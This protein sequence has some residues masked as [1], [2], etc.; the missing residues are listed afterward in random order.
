MKRTAWLVNV[1]RGRL[2]VERALLRALH[3]GAIAGAV[4]DAF[5]DEPL[6]PDSPFYGLPN[7]IVT[8]QTSW[9]SG[10]VLRATMELFAENL[11]RYRAGEPLLNMVDPGAGY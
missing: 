11:R 6:L 2:I 10:R 3:E 8:P 1:A 5:R 4:L 9:S 7:V